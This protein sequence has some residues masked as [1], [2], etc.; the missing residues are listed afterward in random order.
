MLEH[1]LDL[2][3]HVKIYIFVFCA[4]AFLTVLTVLVSYLEH[5]VA[6]GV[7]V[8]LLIATIKGSL[9]ACYFMHLIS[10]RKMIY[11]ILV[12]TGIIFLSLMLLTLASY[13][14][15]E[16]ELHRPAAAAAAQPGHGHVP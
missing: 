5:T 7:M 13:M 8:A 12:F 3:K 16:G 1:A 10:E 15:Q 6:V 2:H 11:T 14:D 4:L 9:V